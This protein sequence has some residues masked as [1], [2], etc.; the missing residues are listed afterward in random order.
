MNKILKGRSTIYFPANGVQSS[1]QA[2]VFLSSIYIDS[3]IVMVKVIFIVII[4]KLSLDSVV[5]AWL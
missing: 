1:A 2:S 3:H 5:R 4:Y